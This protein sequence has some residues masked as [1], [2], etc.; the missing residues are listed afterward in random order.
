MLGGTVQILSGE[1]VETAQAGDL[2]VV[3]PKVAHVF[4]A[5]AGRVTPTS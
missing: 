1:H 5:T 3:P 2:I 4:A